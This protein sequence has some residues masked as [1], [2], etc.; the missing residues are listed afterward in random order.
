MSS[1]ENSSFM[2]LLALGQGPPVAAKV[3]FYLVD[4]KRSGEKLHAILIGAC[5]AGK[6]F[7]VENSDFF[8]QET[9]SSHT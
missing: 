5:F 4:S 8:L 6:T 1:L 7:H 9:L 3:G 2:G